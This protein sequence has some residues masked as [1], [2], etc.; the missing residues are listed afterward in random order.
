MNTVWIRER[1]INEDVSVVMTDFDLM[2]NKRTWHDVE[3]GKHN[4]SVAHYVLL[5]K[6]NGKT[7]APTLFKSIVVSD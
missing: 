3:S 1:E 6:Y 2:A 7:Y 4:F 5:E